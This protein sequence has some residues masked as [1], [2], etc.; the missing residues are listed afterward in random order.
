MRIV[1][2]GSGSIDPAAAIFQKHFSPIIML[3]TKRASPKK[4][5]QLRN[6]VQEIKIAGDREIDFRATLRWLRETWNVKRLLCEGGGELTTRYSGRVWWMKS[7]RPSVQKSLAGARRRR[8]RTAGERPV[9]R[10]RK[11]LN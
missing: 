5:L 6:L 11:N 1:V 2:S 9:W 7:M 4:L 8:W 10:T 3:T